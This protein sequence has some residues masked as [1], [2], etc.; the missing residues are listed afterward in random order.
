VFLQYW[1]DHGA[2][3]QQGLPKTS[4]FLET[5][6]TDGKQ[7]PTQYFERARFEYHAEN[8]GTPYVVLLGLLGRE[9]YAPPRPSPS[10]SPSPSP[11]SN[12]IF[13]DTFTDPTS[14]WPVVTDPQGRYSAGYL[15]GEY[16]LTLAAANFVALLPNLKVGPQANAQIEADMKRFG[17][18]EE[19]YFGLACRAVDPA[20]FYGAVINTEGNALL[21]KVKGGDFVPLMMTLNHPAIKRGNETNRVSFLCQ[22]NQLL[23]AVNGAPVAAQVDGDF[24]SGY[25]GILGLSLDQGGLDLHVLNFLATRP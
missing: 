9:Q 5:N 11:P 19:P 16:R 23:L 10:P 4:L 17:T 15:P 20:N 8:A 7:Y 18:V 1:Q 21:F 14:G 2:L 25:F 24:G 3:A 6:P 12:V 13:R 22:G